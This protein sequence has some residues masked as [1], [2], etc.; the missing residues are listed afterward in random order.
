MERLL[1]DYLIR[2]LSPNCTTTRLASL[3]DEKVTVSHGET[4][5]FFI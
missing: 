3:A 4:F 5:T 2:S 1:I